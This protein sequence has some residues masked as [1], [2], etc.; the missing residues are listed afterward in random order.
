M[1][2]GWDEGKL[3]KYNI[4]MDTYDHTDV[5]ARPAILIDAYSKQT[6]PFLTIIHLWDKNIDHLLSSKHDPLHIGK[7]EPGMGIDDNL[8]L[9]TEGSLKSSTT[10][11]RMKN[12]KRKADDSS[13]HVENVMKSIINMCQKNDVHNI[14]EGK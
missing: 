14:P 9:L 2:E 7:G 1:F 3:E 6:Y 4:D 5:S 13:N 12:L 8:S 11:P 10:S